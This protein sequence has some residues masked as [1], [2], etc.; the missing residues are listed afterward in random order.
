M[1]EVDP[2][3]A[4]NYLPTEGT[5]HQSQIQQACALNVDYLAAL[6]NPEGHLADYPPTF[7]SAFELLRNNVHEERNFAKIALGLPRGF[8]KTSF[9]KM[10]ALY[11]VLFTNRK[12]IFVQAATA[13][14]AEN[15]VS[16]ICYMLSS[17]NIVSAFG[18]WQLGLEKNTEALKKFGFRGRNI[19]IAALGESGSVRGLNLKNV[20]PDVMIFDDIQSR[21]DAVSEA[22]YTKMLGT[23]MKAKAPTGC[24]YVFLANMYPTP[25]SI[26]KKLKH[27][28]NWIKFI[29]G[30]I[31]NDGTSLWEE[32]QPLSQ[33]LEEFDNDLNSGHP[34]IFYS[35][36]LNDETAS[37]NTAIDISK[38]PVVDTSEEISIGNFIVIDPSNDKE[39]SDMVSIGQFSIIN[40]TTVLKE[41]ID[42]RL[43]P[44][45]TVREALQLALRTK[46]YLIVVEGNA[47][48]YSLLYWFKQVSLQ[49]GIQGIN[50]EPIY[51]GKQAKN[52][53]ILNMFKQLTAKEPE[54][55]IDD[56][57]RSMVLS[58]ITSFNPLK[59]NNVDNIL[60]LLTY[61]PRV[62]AE[63]PHLLVLGADYT[64]QVDVIS[65]TE[66][67]VRCSW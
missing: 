53:R 62:A 67:A 58:Q 19:I 52:T 55:M 60:D 27:N 33:L 13:K 24:L 6:A 20:R 43:S 34:E 46:T 16:D 22:I 9:M 8:G 18:D 48:Q 30:G 11:V 12:F 26:L 64:E 36:V 37:I 63:M 25:H 10:F 41:L 1:A 35:E 47:Y 49:Y 21:E 39:N 50:F 56:K 42:D 38:I 44:G 28:S 23:T 57:V 45:D 3:G 17:P 31:L 2:Y 66:S 51:S 4:L 15:F 54:V 59:G 7:H 14:L 61:A 5:Y 40:G 29:A 65:A 32:V